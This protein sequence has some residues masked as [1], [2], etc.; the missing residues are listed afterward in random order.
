MI[1]KLGTAC[2]LVDFFVAHKR[3]FVAYSSVS[4]KQILIGG[5]KYFLSD[6]P[7]KTKELGY[8][9][10]VRKD[11]RK[12]DE[13]QESKFV[14]KKDIRYTQ[15]KNIAPGVYSD[16][17]E[18]DLNSAYHECA[19]QLGII[20]RATYEK[21]LKVSKMARLVALGALASNKAVFEFSGKK[22]EYK[23]Q[24]NEIEKLEGKE[25]DDL[26]YL[27]FRISAEIGRVISDVYYQLNTIGKDG[28]IGYWVDA[29]FVR[30]ELIGEALKIIN[31]YGYEA[32]LKDLSNVICKVKDGV[33]TVWMVER[34]KI[35][36]P[37]A[38]YKDEQKHGKKLFVQN[39]DAFTYSEIRVKPFIVEGYKREIS[40]M[41]T[42]KKALELSLRA[43]R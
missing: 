39:V 23:G 34:K 15:I 16:Y 26:S 35:K 29:V 24:K 19:F 31:E 42:A 13:S 40:R 38:G 36:L 37:C 12:Y 4:S 20:S 22:L 33:K 32:K 7:L 8:L 28:C 2:E 5:R 9:S 18:L 17:V 10:T 30:R 41:S 14:S 27:F 3:P 21:G 25:K 6:L 43:I 11:A 1:N